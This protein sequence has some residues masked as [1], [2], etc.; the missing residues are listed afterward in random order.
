VNANSAAFRVKN[1]DG[2]VLRTGAITVGSGGRYSFT[3]LLRASHRGPH[4]E[5]RRCAV[6]VQAKDNAGNRGSK[7]KVVVL[8]HH[9][10]EDDENQSR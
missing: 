8:P 7:T 4:L 10:D 2:E 3:V 1:E 5:G 9:A 6:T